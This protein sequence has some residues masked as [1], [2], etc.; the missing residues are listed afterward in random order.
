VDRL[1][2]VGQIFAYHFLDFLERK[3]ISQLFN[4]G[5]YVLDFANMSYGIF[6]LE[7]TGYDLVFRSNLLEYCTLELVPRGFDSHF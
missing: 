2:K 6:I 3:K 4:S 7:K 1:E 5:G